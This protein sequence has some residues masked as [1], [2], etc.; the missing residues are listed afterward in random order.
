MA[1]DRSSELVLERV[2]SE[3]SFGRI[4][5][6]RYKATS[7]IVAVK[8][9]PAD[10]DEVKNEIYFLSKINS[11]YTV[12]YFGSF[13]C[14]SDMW[15]ITD[16]C[17]GGFVSDYLKETTNSDYIMPEDCIQAVCAGVVSALKYLHSVNI[18]QRNIRCSS[19]LLT[20]KGYVKLTG[21]RFSAELDEVTRKCKSIVGSSPWMAPEVRN[22]ED[23]DEKA[24]VFSLGMTIIELAEGEPPCSTVKPLQAIRRI[25][26]S[27]NMSDF[28]DCCC[29]KDPSERGESKSLTSHPFVQDGVARDWNGLPLFPWHS[30]G[31]GEEEDE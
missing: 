27:E 17:G 18:C 14:G 10:S 11:P 23:Y 3:G 19:V 26:P 12:G 9:T 24:D 4:F 1:H 5:R 22:G 28:I 13:V 20:N 6:A 29:K 7:S 16:Y 25:V 8:L 31:K 2:V 21:F 15:V 30:I